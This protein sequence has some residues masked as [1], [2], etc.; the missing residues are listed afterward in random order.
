M[1]TNYGSAIDSCKFCH[2]AV[3]MDTKY[4]SAN[5]DLLQFQWKNIK[6]VSNFVWLLV[7]EPRSPCPQ[8]GILTTKLRLQHIDNNVNV[9]IHKI[10][11]F[12]SVEAKDSR[13]HRGI[14]ATTTTTINSPK[15]N[16]FANVYK[17]FLI[18][19]VV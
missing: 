7:F 2:F 15:V 18:L 16:N 17:D 9:E 19:V 4:G 13:L 14:I 1:D 6:D 12:G 5:I 3:L 8:R 10:W 11:R